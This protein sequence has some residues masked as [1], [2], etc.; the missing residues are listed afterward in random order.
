[1]SVARTLSIALRGLDGTV[2][3]VETEVGNGL[4]AFTIVGLPDSSTLQA[5]ERVRGA[6]T[7][8]GHRVLDR[9]L[10]V[11][12]TPAWIPKQGSG[13]DLAI[14][15]STL[16]SL[17]VVPAEAIA[18]VAFLGELTLDAGVRPIPGILPALLAAAK[19]GVSTVVVPSANLAEAQLVPGISVTGVD[20]LASAIELYGGKAHRAK[21]VP[22]FE[23]TAR[24]EPTSTR[25]NESTIGDFSDV[26]GQ[27]RAT[28][29][30]R[31]AAA[32]GHHLMLIGPPGAGKTMIASRIPT[33][34]PELD[35]AT[36][37]ELSAVT[38]V[39][40]TFH[41]S[42]G[43]IR[44]APF[45]APHHTATVPAVIG[46]GSGV[47]GPGAISRAHGGV[48][49]LDEAPEFAPRVLDALRE[50]LESGDIALQRTKGLTVYPARFQLVLAANPCPCGRSYGRGDTCTCSGAQRRRY[51]TKLS[52]PIVDRIDLRLT[53]P[54]ARPLDSHGT[55]ATSAQIR[56]NVCEARARQRHRLR[57]TRFELNAHVT[58]RVLTSLMRLEDRDEALLVR[59]VERG[60]LTMRGRDRVRR[61]AWSVADLEG[62][63]RP[64][65]DD[66]ACALDLR[67]QDSA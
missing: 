27:E 35:D 31:I 6:C 65:N 55:G 36:A 45:V 9:R 51:L 26:V 11:N 17:R 64:T 10:T 34:L 38:S 5:R 67:G 50:P 52:G 23:S 49:F 63:T 19:E 28:L 3:E 58:G 66:V 60:T 30:A 44:R 46:G 20:H 25:G 41:A 2:V 22:R 54:P 16:A 15:M 18:H 21:A 4:P 13:F 24:L 29:A 48:L 12:L 47:A 61:V 37:L 56:E 1:M 57:D 7:H 32:G 53:L 42:D 33:I 59:A 40:G 8:V 14:A 43:L 62:H 39:A